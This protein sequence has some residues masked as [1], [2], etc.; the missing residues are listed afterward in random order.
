MSTNEIFRDALGRFRAEKQAREQEQQEL[1]SIAET[2]L[3]GMATNQRQ[4][5]ELR[6]A[7]KY[8]VIEPE[9]PLDEMTMADYMKV[10]DG[11]RAA[12]GFEDFM[13]GEM[14]EIRKR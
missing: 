6:E 13:N 12:Y 3:L 14:T 4:Y 11:Q 8:L 1:R 2:D 7:Q 5:E 9:I 10:R